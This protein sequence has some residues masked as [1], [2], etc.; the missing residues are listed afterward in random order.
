M[1]PYGGQ[2]GHQLA[3]AQCGEAVDILGCGDR[4]DDLVRIDVLRQRHLHQDAVDARVRVQRGDALQQR[5]FGEV[6]RVALQH[7]AH[8][9]AFAVGD[10]VL[11][12]DLAGRIVADQDHRQAGAMA[13]G[14]QRC[15]A[16][17]HSCAQGAG[18]RVAVDQLCSHR[19]ASVV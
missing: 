5:G 11:H 6:G 13:L 15:G 4:L 7:R 2:A 1:Q 19:L 3:G 9:G 8:A 16:F 17:R 12:V 10:L 18:E 14:R